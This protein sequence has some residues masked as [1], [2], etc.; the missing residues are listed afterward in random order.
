MQIPEDIKKMCERS[1]IKMSTNDALCHIGDLID[2]SHDKL[3]KKGAVRALYLLTELSKRDLSE[4]DGAIIEYFRANAWSALSKINGNQKSWNWENSE[5]QS[6][7]L[8]LSRALNHSGFTSLDKIRQCQ[9]LTN[10]S[11]LLNTVGRS[12]DAIAGWDRALK[13]IPGFAIA[14]G[15][16]GSGLSDYAR[17]LEDDEM[18][19]IFALHAFDGLLSTMSN[20]AVFDS[21]DPQAAINHFANLANDISQVVNIDTVREYQ[22]L[23]VGY[24]GRSKSEKIYRHWCLENR[25]FLNPLN[26]L[27]LYPAAAV[28]NHMLPSLTFGIDE[29]EDNYL[30]PAIFGFFSQIKQEYV[31]ARFMLFEGVSSTRFHFSDREVKLT[32]TLDYSIYSLATEKIRT[33]FRIA[34]SLLD[35]IAFLVNHYWKLD[36]IKD[37]IN[38]KNVWMIEGKSQLLPELSMKPNLPLRGLFWLSKEIFDND[39]KNT[40]AADA[41]ELHNIRNALEHS[42]LRVIDGWAKPFI[43]GRRSDSLGI[44]I[45]SDELEAKAL[46]IFQIARSA[47]FYLSYAIAIE[48]KN[49][50]IKNS[51]GLT[52]PMNLFSIPE[53]DKKRNNF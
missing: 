24:E 38:F 25:L 16:R 47:L 42:Y 19:A 9:I 8:A 39:L 40:T 3:F 34:Y 48:E 51:D 29:R 10:H 15:N 1:I 45:G 50:K 43:N 28:D 5:T 12:I 22:D 31:S 37:R 2:N 23:H 21:P 44:T 36:K 6:E 18:R 53:K 11:I 41:R 32:D 7:L 14:R 4:A 49:K 52:M 33:A 20:D 27:G 13:I 17:L 30:P 35:K 26:D 46:R